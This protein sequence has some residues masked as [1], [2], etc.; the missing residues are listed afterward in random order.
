MPRAVQI[1]VPP[2]RSEELVGHIRQL[3][4]LISLRLHHQV[5]LKSPGDLISLELTDRSLHDLMRLLES[6]GIGRDPDTSIST[7]TPS[8]VISSQF[9]EPICND[10]NEWTWEEMEVEIG[11]QSNMTANGML[12]MA[13]SGVIATIGLA[14]G[15]IHLVIGAMLIAPGFEPLSRISLGLAA[16]SRAWR[17]GL[18]HTVL[19]Y[20]ALLLAAIATTFLLSL[21]AMPALDGR[22]PS[23]T[24]YLPSNALVSYWSNITLIS[25]LASAA[26]SVAGAI[27]IAAGRAILTGGVMIALALIPTMTLTGIAAASGDWALSGKALG[28]WLIDVACVVLLSGLVFAWKRR[29]V[30]GRRSML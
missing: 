8:S 7:S 27:L 19:A 2:A 1:T 11:R 28:R 25:V 12:V 23:D 3:D 18:R 24:S 15:A 16:G 29:A 30:H 6:R 22:D 9:L 21:A 5:S 10:R 4:G 26:A 20:A 13:I 17:R 14:T